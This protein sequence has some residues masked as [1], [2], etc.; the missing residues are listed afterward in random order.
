LASE[1]IHIAPSA[2]GRQIQLLEN[3]FGVKLFTRNKNGL[4][5]TSAGESLL[6]RVKRVMGELALAREDIEAARAVHHSRIRLGM[7][8]F[9]AREMFASFFPDFHAEYPDIHFDLIVAHSAELETKLAAD[10]LDIAIGCSLKEQQGVRRAC[11]VDIGY[12]VLLQP[13]HKLAE[14]DS[15]T[16]SDLVDETFV[17]PSSSSTIRQAFEEVFSS[18]KRPVTPIT[19]D[20]FDLISA[21]VCDGSAIGIHHGRVAAGRNKMVCLPIRDAALRPASVSCCVR[22]SA[23][24]ATALFLGHLKD[25][26]ELWNNA[27][28]TKSVRTPRRQNSSLYA[29]A[30]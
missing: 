8:E 9:I 6:L 25:A 5:L 21:L 2:I 4:Q 3:E 10:E 15:V 28:R 19:A 7:N 1:K 23:S 24:S 11:S 27:A 20:S 13:G 17:L 30:R 14:Q 16:L 22:E 26:L 18:F 29:Q 12:F